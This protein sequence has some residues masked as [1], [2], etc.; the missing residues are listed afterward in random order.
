MNDAQRH[1][2]ELRLRASGSERKQELPALE[3]VTEPGDD[4]LL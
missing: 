1:S 3:P 2:P 4:H